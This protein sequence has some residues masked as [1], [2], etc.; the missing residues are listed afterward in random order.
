MSTETMIFY[1]LTMEMFGHFHLKIFKKYWPVQFIVFPGLKTLHHW[2]KLS[3]KIFELINYKIYFNIFITFITCLL[4]YYIGDYF[5][6][7]SRG[8]LMILNWFVLLPLNFVLIILGLLLIVKKW[9][10][11]KNKIEIFLFIFS[12]ILIVFN[13]LLY[14]RLRV[15]LL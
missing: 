12:I 5:H 14:C 8:D 3:I 1:F 7:L 10:L 6:F 11:K 4:I 9:R 15:L 13:L 2:C